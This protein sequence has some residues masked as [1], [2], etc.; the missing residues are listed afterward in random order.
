MI[1]ENMLLILP[2]LPVFIP[3]SSPW[4]NI[5][6]SSING[7]CWLLSLTSSIKAGYFTILCAQYFSER[8]RD[9]AS[10]LRASICWHAV[11]KKDDV[12]R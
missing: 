5:A 2:F 3:S 9:V 11:V 8:Q 6:S 7:D 12:I 4:T 1:F 10:A